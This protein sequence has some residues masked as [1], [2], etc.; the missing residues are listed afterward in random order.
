MSFLE[1]LIV[2]TNLIVEDRLPQLRQIQ[3]M[4]S[5][6]LQQAVPSHKSTTDCRRF[7]HTFHTGDRVWLLRQ[8]MRMT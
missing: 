6:H 4:V 2:S 5:S 1:R 3:A 7:Q 8:Y